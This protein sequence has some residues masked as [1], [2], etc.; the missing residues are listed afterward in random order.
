MKGWKSIVWCLVIGGWCL[1]LGG[2]QPPTTN[3][4]PLTTDLYPD[5]DC[6]L[7]D[8]HER[9]RYNPDGT[10]ET[11]DESW[12]KLLTE[13]GRR[14]ESTVSLDY[15]R[16][17]GEAK[18]VFVKVIDTNGVERTVDVSATTKDTTDNSSMVSNITDPLDRRIVCTVPGLKVGETV[19]V[20]T[21]RRDSHARCE[22]HWA[23]YAV[24][25][26]TLPIVRA[27][28]EVVAPPTLP[29]A[30]I[31]LRHPRG[32]VVSNVTALADGSRVHTFVVTNSPQCFP[33]PDMPPL[34]NEV[35]NLRVSTT[36]SW[37]DISRWYWRLCQPR[38][39]KTTPEMTNC[40][41]SLGRDLT[42]IYRFVSQEIRYM[43]LTME[44]TSPGYAPHDV[45]ITFAKRYGVCR[46][47]AAL[48][49][50]L[51]RIA[52]YKAFPVLIQVGA[53]RD[54][55]VPQPFFNHAIVAVEGER[56][57]YTL[58][59]PTNENAKD[60]FPSYLCDC[61]YLVARPE[62]EDLRTS[63]VTPPE[64]NALTVDSTGSLGKDG[65]I[66]LENTIRFGG[67]NDTAYRNAFVRRKPSDRVKFFERIVRTLSSGAELI[68]CE[69]EPRDLRD[70]TQP[71]AVRLVS[72]L[73]EAILRGETRDALDV[74]LVS[75]A[76]GMV[77]MLLEGNTSLEKRTY[78]LKLDT[79]ACVREKLKL[80]L[81]EAV[82]ETLELPPE[83][84]GEAGGYS[85]VRRM[86]VTNGVL[87]AEREL[88]V[89]TVEF[90]PQ[91]YLK[92][93]EEMKREEAISRQM[94]CFSKDAAGDAN[95]RLRLDRTSTVISS[96]HSWVTTNE[97][98]REVLTYDGKKRCAEMRF[99]YQPSVET[100]DLLEA[101][102]SNRDGRVVTV[103]PKEMNVMDCGWAAKAPRYSAGRMLVVN[104]P[105]VEI[106]SVISYRTVRAVTNAPTGFYA[107]YGFDSTEPMDC[108][109]VSVNGWRRTVKSPR[110]IPNEANQP[111]ASLWRD[112]VIIA[113]N[114][115][116]TVDL[117]IGRAE[118]PGVKTV[119]EIR[120]WMA[121]HV[122]LAG[123]ALWELPIA[124]QLT[125][126]ETVL[127]ERYASRLDYMRTLCA[128]L[129]GAG[130]EAEVVFAADDA[131]DPAVVR[132]RIMHERPNVRA[133]SRALV[134]VAST[135]IGT[136]NEYAPLGA[137]AYA[138]CDYWNP[139][140]GVFGIVT[141]PSIELETRETETSE[142]VVRENGSVDLTVENLIYG[143][144]VGGFRR[145]Y[146][147]ILPEA[148]SRRHQAL[149]GAVA[150]AAT[151]TSELE[152]DFES[153]PA[154]R[155][156]SCFIPDFATVQ[157]ETITIV[158]PPL[159]SSLPSLIGS[160]R[161]TPFAV[162]AAEPE[163]ETV[164][165]RFPEGYTEI[166][167]LP[168]P[169]TLANP[170]DPSEIWL[171][172]GV[173]TAVADGALTVTLSRRVRRRISSWFA[174]SFYELVKD[175]SRLA[176]ARGSRTI[177][178]RR[179]E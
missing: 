107:A 13:K 16:R 134:R 139:E 178:V 108:R 167:H 62:G 92:L 5:A 10:F 31:A 77:N 23:D 58:L 39:E 99:S 128:L 6:V 103:S 79:T 145:S 151:A 11:T 119:R 14:D 78:A 29:L 124:A 98:V 132:R 89:G 47:K 127:R 87:T 8:R 96:D 130:C 161:R 34:Y 35:Q 179:G 112:Q 53:K 159:V 69:I 173:T 143:S 154:R 171:E 73:P 17:Y 50:T 48:L 113:S 70:T 67:I 102:V 20:K 84:R 148:R 25:E 76:L 129:R 85:F 110:R 105:S 141:V 38:M 43:G 160:A 172:S 56:V 30:K 51:L 164:T 88:T 111:A 82:G 64:K 163:E 120:D 152:A 44:D 24:L 7:V 177:V 55:E 106:G 3:H 57:E 12:T 46:D 19:H 74:P 131:D 142:Y 86:A 32:N 133:F 26:W 45:D 117:K 174:P 28:Y 109:E 138:G 153:Y 91:D 1:A 121:K 155:K 52:G 157:G 2:S 122:K 140:T 27:S 136:E 150:Q 115:F 37:R 63:P 9:V 49:A 66:L 71:L 158:I 81:R 114:R 90:S 54:P 18:I 166:E 15:S 83:T 33:D 170:L 22:G 21:W 95:V 137:S 116:E 61:S 104:L 100:F 42:R 93:R 176:G 36:S 97:V 146:A 168:R 156:F 41:E 40:V 125:P 60:A 101:V 126:C 72:R 68:R 175:W 80:D 118:I 162:S 165:I 135:F 94:P 4:Q 147:E 123:P 169:F 65:S 149:L 59:D 75:R 144:G